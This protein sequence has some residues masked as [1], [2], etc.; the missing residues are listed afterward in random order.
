[1]GMASFNIPNHIAFILDGDRRWAKK[2]Q[3]TI[4]EGH[5]AGLKTTIQM[6][7]SCL[8]HGVS[9][10]TIYAV[11]VETLER[12]QVEVDSMLDLC[13]RF[14][15]DFEDQFI[16]Q[17]IRVRAIGEIDELPT[18]TRHVLENLERRTQEGKKMTLTLALNYNGKVDIVQALRAIAVR[19]KAGL[20][21]PEEITESVVR[22]YLT[23][24]AIPNAD[25]IIR[26][27][28][29]NRWNDFF[30]FE[31]ANAE[32]FST[33][34]YWPDFS[35]ELLEMAMQKYSNRQLQSLEKLNISFSIV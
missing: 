33:D 20:V 30:L 12:P 14:A 8:Q 2:N 32:V 31:G 28:G 11:Q 34:K 27:G 18:Q 16:Q 25:L 7:D 29:Q 4:K 6:I 9:F 15:K 21:I 3:K 10:V 5:E 19:A 23:T 1:M 13:S 24:S 35:N 17:S 22:K 26:T